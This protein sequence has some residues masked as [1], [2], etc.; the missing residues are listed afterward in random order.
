MRDRARAH[1]D[2]IADGPKESVK[3]ITADNSIGISRTTFYRLLTGGDRELRD[4]YARSRAGA[5]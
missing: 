3:E 4:R 1:R 2:L 5:S